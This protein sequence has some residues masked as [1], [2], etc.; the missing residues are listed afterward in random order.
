ML[1]NMWPLVLGQK[2]LKWQEKPSGVYKMQQTTGAAGAP[3]RTPLGEVTRTPLPLSA[4]QAS[5]FGLLGLASPRPAFQT[6]SEVKPV[7]PC[8]KPA[9]ILCVAPK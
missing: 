1:R 7:K 9:V 8:V 6:P 4:F 3:P 2:P 5:G